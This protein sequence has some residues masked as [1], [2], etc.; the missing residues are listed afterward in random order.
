[1]LVFAIPRRVAHC[2]Q[3]EEQE[4]EEEEEKVEVDN[5]DGHGSSGVSNEVL[6]F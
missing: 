1:M 4:E 3:G 2:L 5:D 6:S